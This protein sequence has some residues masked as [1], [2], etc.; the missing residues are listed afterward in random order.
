MNWDDN[1]ELSLREMELEVEAEGRDWMR[2]RLQEKLQAQADR[3]GGIFPPERTQ[4]VA[5]AGAATASAQHVR[6]GGTG[7]AVRPGSRGPALGLP[8]ARA[9]GTDGPPTTESYAG[10]QAGL[11][12]HRDRFV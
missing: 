3:L 5:S 6:R 4:R 2:R 1:R 9:M 7:G 11:F 12:C 8:D 10:R